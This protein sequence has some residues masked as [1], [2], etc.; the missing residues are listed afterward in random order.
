MVHVKALHMCHMCLHCHLQGRAL[1]ELR[2]LEE[3]SAAL[4][5]SIQEGQLAKQQLLDDMM[6]AER[7]IML[8][9]RKI[10]LEKE[11]QASVSDCL[12]QQLFAESSAHHLKGPCIP[13]DMQTL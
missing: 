5:S 8:A 4:S 6:E 13:R 3:S 7:Q 1:S 11:M 10:Q 9:E 2:A 12:T